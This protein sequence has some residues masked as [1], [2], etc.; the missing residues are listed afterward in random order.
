MKHKLINYLL[1][2]GALVFSASCAEE[3]W[4]GNGASGGDPIEI[5]EIT[6]NETPQSRAHDNSDNWI[7]VPNEKIVVTA[8]G[9]DNAQLGQA[10]Y[11][12]NMTNDAWISDS[13][14]Q[15]SVKQDGTVFTVSTVM[16]SATEKQ[17]QDDAYNYVLTDYVM[18]TGTEVSFDTDGKLTAKLKHRT[19]DVVAVLTKGENWESDEAFYEALSGCSATF[20]AGGTYAVNGFV[21]SGNDDSVDYNDNAGEESIAPGKKTYIFRAHLDAAQL[22]AGDGDATPLLQLTGLYDDALK[23]KYT[24]PDGVANGKRLT[25]TFSVDAPEVDITRSA[26]SGDS[27]LKSGVAVVQDWLGKRA[28]YGTDNVWDGTT[29]TRPEYNES[30]QTYTI[31]TGAELAWLAGNKIETGQTVRLANNIN[32][33]EGLWTEGIGTSNFNGTFDGCGYVITMTNATTSLFNTIGEGATVRY[34]GVN[35]EINYTADESKVGGIARINKGTIQRCYVEGAITCTA[36]CPGGIAGSNEGIIEDCYST[37][38]V[39]TAEYYAGG[40]AGENLRGTIQRCYA[41][42]AISSKG[43]GGIVGSANSTNTIKNCIALNKSIAGG[44]GAFGAPFRIARSS[45]ETTFADNYASPIIRGTWEKKDYFSGPDGGDLSKSNFIGKGADEEAFKGWLATVWS[46]DVDNANLPILQ[47]F[48]SSVAQPVTTRKSTMIINTISN[49][50]DLKAFRESVNGGKNTYEGETVTLTANITVTGWTTVIGSGSDRY[51]NG[52]FDGAGFTIDITGTSSLFSTINEKGI[53]QNLGMTGNVTDKKNSNA[54]GITNSNYGTIQYCFTSVNVTRTADNAA[55]IA[56]DNSGTI[57]NCY[58]TGT[59]TGTNA[60][61]IAGNNGGTIRNC[62]TTGAITG[63]DNAGGIVGSNASAMGSSTLSAC[64]ATGTITGNEAGGIVGRNGM[65]GKTEKCIALNTGGISGSGTTPVV[66][67]IAGIN[68]SGTLT[69]N[70]ASPGIPSN[71]TAADKEANKTNGADLTADNFTN[72]K[73]ASGAFTSWSTAGTYDWDLTTANLPTLK[74]FTANQPVK[75][76]TR[77][78]AIAKPLIT[79]IA[80]AAD[81]EAFRA[82]VNGG[83][84]YT[85]KT[86]ILTAPITVTGWTTGIGSSKVFAGTFDGQGYVI[87]LTGSTSLFNQIG[88]SGSTAGTVRYLGVKA[89]I[90]ET[91]NGLSIG[92]IAATNFG[93][94]QQCYAEGSITSE[95]LASYA[96]G[97]VGTNKGTVQDCYSTVAITVKQGAGGIV[98]VNRDGGIVQR[99]YA[100]GAITGGGDKIGGIIG[101]NTIVGSSITQCIALNASIT[102]AIG[103]A[104]LGRITGMNTRG[105]LTTNYASPLIDGEWNNIAAGKEDGADL[106]DSNFTGTGAGQGAFTNWDEKV[107]DFGDMTKLPILQGFKGTQSVKDNTRA[108]VMPKPLTIATANEL[109]NFSEA[110]EGGNTYKGK[111]VILTADITLIG[112]WTPIGNENKM[113]AGT[114]KGGGH[115]I[116]GLSVTINQAGI[117]YGGLFGCIDSKG[118]VQNLGVK[119]T[120]SVTSNN[121]TACA[122]GITGNNNGTI[123]NCY[124]D[125]TVTS[126]TGDTK[127]SFDC[128]G[129]IA[130]LN[131]NKISNCYTRGNSTAVMFAGGIVGM[132]TGTI[133]Q[134]YATGA[135]ETTRTTIAGAGGIAGYT[136]GGSYTRKC[137]AL[138]SSITGAPSGRISGKD[139][140]AFAGNYASPAISGTWK[141]IAADG[142]DGETLTWTNYKS[143]TNGWPSVSWNSVG[144]SAKLPTLKGFGTRQPAALLR[145]VSFLP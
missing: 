111:T 6:V 17:N 129:G 38:S 25:V 82:S 98:Q 142:I 100:T 113:F 62:Y 56:A 55:G 103:F 57:R 105:T 121:N 3:D 127:N 47:G 106:D 117:R 110:V 4:R 42:G 95:Q 61:G 93:T 83:G 18:A 5:G 40:I 81:L 68:D 77:A 33:G 32:L 73:N 51:F 120:V 108:S 72:V 99:C 134:C 132:N 2:A 140:G 112:D 39:T 60:G 46:F 13:P 116:S 44:T 23:G 85:G 20:Y 66:G 124:T 53:V 75:D 92:A 138:N 79:S 84:D 63:T 78:K 144:N 65:G 91:A 130:G 122:G 104:S 102:D 26:T 125:V 10:T 24:R 126:S 128:A 141:N 29:K 94:I 139:E 50:A 115:C 54:S 30:T 89:T 9:K 137:I 80:T 133:E 74:G 34:L 107:W 143:A 15:A 59:I 64:Y 28:L 70:H 88:V 21:V 35:A 131:N 96:G 52:T 67:R 109:K 31:T 118:I 145:W 58:T 71:W 86:V 43:A 101:D 76:I 41:T 22:A 19:V 87:D 16:P 7:W 90:T 49:E 119:G 36:S 136:S 12:R 8:T 69:G 135:I 11:H 48:Q 123:Q 97:I 114:F 37:A 1:I 27:S 14:L 45:S